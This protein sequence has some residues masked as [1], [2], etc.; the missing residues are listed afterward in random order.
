[1]RRVGG[2]WLEVTS[3]ANLIRASDRAARGKRRQQ[4]IARFMLERE[5]LLLE[6]RRELLA[7]RY[8]PGPLTRFEILDPKPRTISVAPFRDRVVHHAIID[9]L[10]PI[11]D[12]R[13]IHASFACRRGKGTH[14]ALDHAQRLVRRRRWFLKMDVESFFA[15][16]PHAVVLATIARMIKGPPLLRLIERVIQ[17]GG[18]DRER[19]LPI[20]N[21]TSQWFANLT[22]GRIDRLVVEQLRMP[23]YARYMDDFVSFADDRERL[24]DAQAQIE[25]ELAGL[26]LRAKPTATMLAP[27][28]DGLPF[29]GF[30]LFPAVRRLRPANRKRTIQRW[31]QRLWQYRRGE[32]DERT[33]ADCVRSMMAHLEHGTTRG[34]RRRWCATLE[35]RGPM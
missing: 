13:M 4:A 2:L 10:E 33:L 35:G 11:F 17:A 5:P 27:T 6:L 20:G 25:A 32:L 12:R 31:K 8:R 29:L 28:R 34:W 23:G 14:A 15:S 30:L 21:L 16:I 1:M 7:E 26:G 9:V 19:G 22:L 24:R 3:F 18:D